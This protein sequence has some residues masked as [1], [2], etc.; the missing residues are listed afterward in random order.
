M[1]SAVR[2]LEAQL[3]Q[4][5]QLRGMLETERQ[6]PKTLQAEVLR[7]ESENLKICEHLDKSKDEVVQLQVRRNELWHPPEP[8]RR[9]RE[10]KDLSLKIW[11]GCKLKKISLDL[12][13]QVVEE[14]VLMKP[15]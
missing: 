13:P 3:V 14:W 12:P 10:I 4:I 1:S 7:L 11:S 5:L 15:P 9:V 6:R 8:T 2:S